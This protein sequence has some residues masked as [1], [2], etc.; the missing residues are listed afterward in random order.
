MGKPFVVEFDSAVL[1]GEADGIGLPVVFL[2]AGVADRRMWRD[3]MQAVAQAGYHVISYDRR[4]YGE[5]HS[6]DEPFNHLVD[7]EAVLDHLDIRAAVL[8][9]CSMGGGLAIDFA[10][11][12]PERTVGLVLVGTSITGTDEPE[13]EPEIEPLVQ[14]LDDALERA[15]RDLINQLQA[16]AWLDGPTSVNGRVRGAVRELFF[17]MNGIALHKPDLSQEEE[18]EPAFDSLSA[19][20][21]PTLL[22]VGELDFPY[23]IERHDILS[24]EIE[25]S[26]AVVLEGTAHLPSLER[27][28]L[29]NP[30]LIEFLDAITGVAEEA[31]H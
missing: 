20:S 26:F 11:E 14:A 12:N 4:G 5:T 9:G 8:V 1:T 10:L 24:E 27:P 30:L 19:I 29:F 6:D 7:L 2:H 25:D 18:R 31:K 28:D 15:D 3:Q 21:A 16:H 13:F 17:D 23:I 22:V